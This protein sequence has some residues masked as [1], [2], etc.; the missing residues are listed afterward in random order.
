MKKE[1]HTS[2]IL[3][4]A[5][6]L[7]VKPNFKQLQIGIPKES[8]FQ[9]NRVSLTPDSV[10]LLVNNGHEIIIEKR[11]V[12]TPYYLRELGKYLGPLAYPTLL[13]LNKL[14]TSCTTNF[15]GYCRARN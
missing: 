5:E 13:I 10:S 14:P 3:P 6:M 2:L 8:S 1:L 4:K 9:E 11:D 12:C 15:W 7:E